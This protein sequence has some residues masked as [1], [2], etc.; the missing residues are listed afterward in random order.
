MHRGLEPKSQDPRAQALPCTAYH[1]TSRVSRSHPGKPNS[2]APQDGCFASHNAGGGACTQGHGPAPPPARV[3]PSF[4]AA[5]RH[6]HRR[7][8]RRH[9]LCH[10][11]Q[12][13]VTAACVSVCLAWPTF[14]ETPSF[15]CSPFSGPWWDR[16][17]MSIQR[18]QPA[19][20]CLGTVL[21]Q[22]PALLHSP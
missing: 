4:R 14:P 7:R 10:S 18:C 8:S 11:F 5:Q 13:R 12:A 21:A 1:H 6:L 15:P 2:W 9:L 3:H 19:R 20:V 17:A 16:T 22:R